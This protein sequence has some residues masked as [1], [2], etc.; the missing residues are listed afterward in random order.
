MSSR[1]SDITPKEVVSLLMESSGERHRD[2]VSRR[3]I[4]TRRN[5]KFMLFKCPNES[6][7]EHGNIMCEKGKG[8]TNPYNHLK[9]C[10]AG[11]DENR[12]RELYNIRLAEKKGKHSSNRQFSTAV[13][14]LS[15]REKALYS[16]IRLI[17][18]HSLPLQIVTCHDYRAFSKFDIYFGVGYFKEILFKLEE[19]VEEY[20]S[21]EMKNTTGAMMYDGW[22]QFGTHFIGIFALY[23]RSVT[24]LE[25]G[26]KTEKLEVASPLISVSP[27]NSYN[28]DDDGNI[29]AGQDATRFCA[30]THMRHF[31]DIFHIF[32]VSVH[33]WV[34]C[35]IADNCNLNL[36]I[37]D[38]MEIAHVG[39][40]SHKLNL[41]VRKMLSTDGNLRRTVG[42]I[43]ETMGT[44][45][46]RLK[47]RAM[48]RNVSHLQPI[49]PNE[50]RWSGVCQMVLRYNKIRDALIEIEKN[51]C[52]DLKMDK[53][54]SFKHNALKIGSQLQGIDEFTKELQ[55]EHITLSDARLILDELIRN[56]EC[57]K[58]KSE[59]KFYTCQLGREY[60]S[61]KS[62]IVSHHLFESGVV[63]IQR[64]QI[65]QM[66]DD[67]KHACSKLCSSSAED[68]AG[69]EE[70]E[71]SLSERLSQK[72][73]KLD[74]ESSGFRNCDYILGSVAA[75]ER[76]WSIAGNIFT[77]DRASMS[78]LLLETLL[79]LRINQSY[80][81]EQTVKLAV[82][83]A[84]SSRVEKR[85][86]EDAE[87]DDL[88]SGAE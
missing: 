79:F 56:V 67:E 5:V 66:S 1:N 72:K 82:A 32:G 20:I 25:K 77:K 7:V 78:P 27:M 54:L 52:T 44:C 31:E 26:K 58:F 61:T 34:S 46:N 73:R 45:R 9:T 13:M 76:L 51:E 18:F 8:F 22:T 71:L 69:I 41:E 59:S 23:N 33:D 84:K 43:Q 49:I 2:I 4:P 37:A 57:G 86:N 6:C 28:T 55:K 68:I 39:C 62:S 16:Y 10:I 70:D 75:C 48:L 83:R 40:A 81:N 42:S 24:F 50:T 11:G 65:S 35:Q 74:R 17:V 15:E 85:L 29:I 14:Q 80:W 19:L 60:I 87:Y 36:K 64:R 3:N 88:I 21:V 53:Q 63:K 30:E 12:L 47:N 38:I